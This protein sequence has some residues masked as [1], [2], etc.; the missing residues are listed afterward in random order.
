MCVSA[1]FTNALTEFVTA[2]R[3][4][5]AESPSSN[6]EGLRDQPEALVIPGL[7]RLGLRDVRSILPRILTPFVLAHSL[8]AF[9]H[10]L[11]HDVPNFRARAS[12]IF[13]CCWSNHRSVYDDITFSSPL[14]PDDMY[15]ILELEGKPAHLSECILY[16]AP[17][18]KP[19]LSEH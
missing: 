6:E 11:W 2:Y 8:S 15:E 7:W 4:P 3:L 18:I 9:S 19:K 1:V 12:K 5:S 16:L 17:V 10:F 13:T 14:N